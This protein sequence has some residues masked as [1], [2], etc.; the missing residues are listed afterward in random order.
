MRLVAIVGMTGSG[1]TEV[2]KIFQEHGYEKVRF[3]QA[4]LDE[5]MR[6][7]LEVNE[8]NERMVREQLREEHGMAAMAV[9][10][11]PKIKKLLNSSDV[12]IDN[13]M[14]WEEYTL[15]K[16]NFGEQVLVIAVYAD[17]NTRYKRLVNRKLTKDDKKAINR[18]TTLE[19]SRSR[20]YSEI[21]NLHKAGPIAMADFTIVNDG[22]IEDLRANVERL[23]EELS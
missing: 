6:R 20:D 8:A 7:G 16:K 21:E 22:A 15:L 17:P 18:P 3:G 9:L 10:A 11:L 4:V 5:V 1:K 13:L 14:S 19:E 12:V 23:I 2:A